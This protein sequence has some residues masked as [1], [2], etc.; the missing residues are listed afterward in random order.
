MCQVLE[1]E[2]HLRHN[3]VLDKKDLGQAW[4]LACQAIPIS[5]QLRI[6]FPQ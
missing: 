3:E 4:T 6:R 2:V 5:A 1:G